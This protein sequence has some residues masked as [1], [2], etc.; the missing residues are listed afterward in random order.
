MSSDKIIP[1]DLIPIGSI[2]KP[3]GL[4][5]ELKVFLYNSDSKTLKEK[6]N[7][8]IRLDEEKYHLLVVSYFLSSGKYKIIK[9]QEIDSI[10]ESEVLLNKELYVSRRDFDDVETLYL[11]DLIDFTV[12][13]ELGIDYG[14]VKD[15]L[16]FPTNNSL[17]FDYKEEEVMI[18]IIDDFIE[19][20]DFKNKV[21]IIKNSDT[22]I[23]KC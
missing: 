5:G 7:V 11:V 18:P 19:L 8:W 15:I 17:L 20:F 16:N 1:K 23:K 13:D 10:D 21:V 3:K 6:V 4:K 9:F 12:K 22:F 2:I 14:K